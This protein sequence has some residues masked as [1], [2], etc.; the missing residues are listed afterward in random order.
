MGDL[1]TPECADEKLR[2]KKPFGYCIRHLEQRHLLFAVRLRLVFPHT[3]ALKLDP[4]FVRVVGRFGLLSGLVEE[5][6]QSI[7]RHGLGKGT[8]L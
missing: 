2:M 3:P 8:R 6:G 1:G 7:M 5:N 4:K